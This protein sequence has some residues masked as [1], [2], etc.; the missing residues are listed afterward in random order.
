MLVLRYKPLKLM[1]CE[2]SKNKENI[3]NPTPTS[4]AFYSIPKVFHVCS[5][6]WKSRRGHGNRKKYSERRVQLNKPVQCGGNSN[7]T[8]KT[9]ARSILSMC[10]ARMA[11][12]ERERGRWPYLA[13]SVILCVASRTRSTE[14][15]AGE[16]HAN[17][18]P[19][20][21][22]GK[23]KMGSANQIGSR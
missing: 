6:R 4:F 23:W 7:I 14:H 12:R 19:P 18:N 20:G 2:L 22:A 17:P 3:E 9:V 10:A 13:P 16:P 8:E 15:R 1:Y 5:G 11:R 21:S